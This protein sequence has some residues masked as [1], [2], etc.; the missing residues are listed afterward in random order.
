MILTKNSYYL[1]ALKNA[2]MPIEL[3]LLILFVTFLA[4]FVNSAFGFGEGMIN[5]SVLSFFFPLNFA[6][7]FVA[8]LSGLGSF[9]IILRDRSDWSFSNVKL[10][11]LAAVFTVPTGIWLASNS[12][13]DLMRRVLGIIIA[14]FSIYSLHKAKLGHLYDDRWALLFGGLGGILGGAYNVSGPPVVI[15]GNLRAWSPAVFRVTLQVYFAALSVIVVSTHAFRGNLTNELLLLVLYALPT[16]FI[17]IIVGRKVN[18][19]IKNPEFF[20][21]LIYGLLLIVGTMLIFS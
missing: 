1:C 16:A 18:R 14:G 9:Y 3:L 13:T 19:N 4:A 15:Y 11:I 2:I 7:P 5:M 17:G 12:D 20:R 10:L 21:K 6:A 8:L